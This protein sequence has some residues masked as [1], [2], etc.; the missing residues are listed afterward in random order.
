MT[1][2]LRELLV[3]VAL[4]FAL[5]FCCGHWTFRSAPS[6]VFIP[7]SPKSQPTPQIRYP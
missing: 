2:T 5:G 4:A 3:L 1:V 7:L 6:V